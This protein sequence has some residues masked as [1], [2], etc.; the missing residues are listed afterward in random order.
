MFLV[1]DLYINCITLKPLL[2][3][4]YIFYKIVLYVIFLQLITNTCSI[5]FLFFSNNY[6]I[7]RTCQAFTSTAN[8]KLLKVYLKSFI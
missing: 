6:S 3:K 7:T 5:V 2:I 1:R 8:D 4:Q